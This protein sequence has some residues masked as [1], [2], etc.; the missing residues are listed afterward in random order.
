VPTSNVDPSGI[1]TVAWIAAILF[2]A[3]A[4]MLVVAGWIR[5]RMRGE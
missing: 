5:R 1:W 2:L 4:G 3:V